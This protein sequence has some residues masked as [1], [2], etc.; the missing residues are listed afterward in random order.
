MAN[1]N[2]TFTNKTYLLQ[3]LI[4]DIDTGNI[5][6]PDLQRPYVWE[7]T[8]ARDLI[9]SLY[10]GMPVGFIILWEILEANSYRKINQE[11]KREPRFLVI[12][13]QQR[14]TSL[15]SIIKDKEIVSKNV[16]R[17]KIK[18]SFNPIEEK[19]EVYN[20][21]IE[22]SR[23]WIT[24]I[25]K[26]F[27][28]GST[29]GLVNDYLNKIKDLK[30]DINQEIIAT[31]IEKVRNIL[32]FPF[33]VLELSTDLDPEE[34]SEIFVRI[35]SKGESLNQSDFILT[36]MSVY[37]PE[38]REQLE[39]F[40][41]NSYKM[42]QDNKPSSYNIIGIKPT[43]EQLI[44]TIVGYAFD[45]GRLKYAYLILKGR[46]LENR[47]ISEE[48]R[49]KNFEIF[50]SGQEKVINLTNWHDFIKI[51]H[52]AGF[53]DEF[54]ISSKVT[55]FITY[56]IYLKLIDLKSVI[57]DRE[58]DSLVKKWFVFSIITQRY[59]GSPESKIEEDFN[60]MKDRGVVEFIKDTVNTYLT[61]DFWHIAL[62]EQLQSSSIRNY[63][64]LTYLA[65][66]IFDDVKV[67]FSD[68]KLRDYLKPQFKSNKKT[69]DLHHIYPRSFLTTHFNLKQ[70]D[71]NQVAN[72]VY[73]EYKDNIKISD[74]APYDYWPEFI[75][76]L[77][78][79]EI[80][81]IYDTCSLPS[82]FPKMDYFDFLR[83]RRKLMA[84]KIQGYFSKL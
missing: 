65:S 67:L 84:K 44:R 82:G 48:L 59:T 17:F 20:V 27:E 23:E 73:I 21:A 26:I 47:V 55:F 50:R 35:N 1:T 37:W 39:N 60:K 13:G 63:A 56:A 53:I 51:I 3:N 71:Y 30:N 6:L 83:E 77:S 46:D 62:P 54:L 2:L 43:P 19:F 22:K 15:Y 79:N 72:F 7:T 14:L 16:H 24:D 31:R 70:K 29:Y 33:Q 42:P 68:I 38:G 9:D 61:N 18:I 69:I 11:N 58:I 52:S 74:K 41:K 8:K 36:L 78:D 28:T 40:H 4:N 57:S 12:D 10:K 32:N 5:A 76:N 66:L 25:S 81:Q 45:R 49:K 64:Y 75:K 80:N 34:V